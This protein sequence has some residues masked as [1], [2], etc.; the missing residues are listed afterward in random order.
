[1]FSSWSKSET[2][3]NLKN[4]FILSNQVSVGGIANPWLKVL[5]GCHTCKTAYFSCQ[6]PGF[7]RILNC[8]L[9]IWGTEPS[10]F[11]IITFNKPTVTKPFGVNLRWDI[12]FLT[13]YMRQIKRIFFTHPHTDYKVW[14]RTSLQRVES[15][16]C[17]AYWLSLTCFAS[18]LCMLLRPKPKPY[19]SCK[20]CTWYGIVYPIV[21]TVGK[22]EGAKS[23]H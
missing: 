23:W 3:N 2:V 12:L 8:P 21:Q 10:K 20:I 9:E 1:M 15:V 4:K 5:I 6:D 17:L 19:F 7:C 18:L 16:E 22:L 11:L 14:R 13:F